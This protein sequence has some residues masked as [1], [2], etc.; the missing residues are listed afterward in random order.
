MYQSQTLFV[1]LIAV[2]F[3]IAIA[4]TNQVIKAIE[5]LTT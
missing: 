1:L 3:V 4:Q 2:L 5:L